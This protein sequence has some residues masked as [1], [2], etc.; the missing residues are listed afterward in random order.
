MFRSLIYC[1]D[2]DPTCLAMSNDIINV[3]SSC[4]W[5]TDV[6]LIQN[7]FWKHLNFNHLSLQLVLLDCLRLSQ[8]LRNWL[9]IHFLSNQVQQ[10]VSYYFIFQIKIKF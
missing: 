10:I 4:A 1:F 3:L 6:L 7:V 8:T 2:I 9:S 5:Q